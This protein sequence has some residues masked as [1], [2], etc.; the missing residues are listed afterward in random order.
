MT[1][2]ENLHTGLFPQYFHLPSHGWFRII[3][4][5]IMTCGSKLILLSILYFVGNIVVADRNNDRVSLFTPTG[6]FIRH[7]VTREDGVR[8][9]Y[10]VAVSSARNLII[11]ES[12]SNRA[13]LKLFQL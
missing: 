6:G 8:D 9:P 1:Y 11:T 7:L 2:S 5:W 4:A 3:Q 12:G 10:G 13:S